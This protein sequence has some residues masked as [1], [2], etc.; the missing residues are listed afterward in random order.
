MHRLSHCDGFS[1]CRAQALGAWASVVEA[2][3]LSYP[4]AD[5]WDIPGAGIEPA[6]LAM[7]RAY[8]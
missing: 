2:H 8:S 7:A 5:I 3:E 6:S 4:E 1:L